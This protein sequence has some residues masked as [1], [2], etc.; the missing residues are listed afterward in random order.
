[1][2]YLAVTNLDKYQH[3]KDRNIIWIKWHIDCLQDYEFMSL[4]PEERWI[5]IGLICL[6]CKCNNKINWDENWIEKILNVS[7]ISKIISKLLA[8]NLLS[9]CYHRA[10]PI[11]EDKIREEKRENSFFKKPFFKGKEMRKV[12]GKWFVLPKDGGEWLEFAAP[13]KDIEWR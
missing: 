6:A 12:K 5:F 9:R 7:Q 4:K 10:I 11:R 1:M 3:Y 2:K 13:L 8:I